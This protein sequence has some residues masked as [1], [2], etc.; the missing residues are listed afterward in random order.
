MKRV[1]ILHH[2]KLAPSLPLAH[3]IVSYLAGKGI[4][5]WMGSAWD[6]SQVAPR[7]AGLDLLI[8]LGGDGTILRAARMSA[9]HKV[10]ILGINLGRLGFLTELTPENWEE[11]LPDMLEG[12]YWIE[13]RMMLRAESSRRDSRQGS[14]EALNDVVISR[15]GL[16]RVVRVETW[17]DG[18]RLT[19]YIADGVIVATATGSSAYA[20]AVGGP[21]MPPALH[22]ILLIPIAP[23]LTLDRAIILPQGA[24]L[25]LK[26]QTD[27]RARLTVDGQFDQNLMDGDEVKVQASE[28]ICRFVRLRS[29][30]YFY[31]SLMERLRWRA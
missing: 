21:I 20:L 3:H 14:Y 13:E 6:E 16:A 17:V 12:Y 23:H 1:G 7:I 4:D 27:H 11:K 9:R 2:P 5:S 25:T 24:T 15:G 8:T 18:S 29:E 28:H 31:E 10:P 22:N 26:L 30:T 19:T